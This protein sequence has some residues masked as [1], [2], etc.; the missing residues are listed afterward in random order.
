MPRPGLGAS[1]RLGTEGSEEGKTDGQMDIGSRLHVIMC[2]IHAHTDTHTCTFTSGL[3]FSIS[4][5][6]TRA[7]GNVHTHTHTPTHTHP[8]NHT[9][10]VLHSLLL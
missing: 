10:S 7:H 1:A 4:R 6:C 3:I 5:A 2:D 8:H 9:L